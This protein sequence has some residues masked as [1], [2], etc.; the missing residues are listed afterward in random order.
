M[1]A[2]EN[3]QK[4]LVVKSPSNKKEQKKF[5]GYEWCGAKGQ[6]GIKY[7]GGDTVNDIITPLFNPKNRND[8]T[9]INYLIQQNFLGGGKANDLNDF[10]EYKDLITY[11]NVTDLLD[12]SRKDF[13][14]AI[15]L[16]PKK[17][18]IIET[19]WPLVKLGDEVIC[20]P[21]KSEISNLND[22]TIVSFI[23]MSSVSNKGYIKSKVDKT[24]KELKKGGFTYFRE[25]DIIIA[26]ITPSME[27]GKCA[28][29]KDLTNNIGLGS[30]EFHIFRPN[31][32]LLPGYL[33]ALLNQ[34]FIRIEAAVQMTG[35][36]GHRRVPIEFYE[37][38]KIPLPPK[39]IQ[40]KIV[41]ECEAIDKEVEKAQETIEKA[42]KEI[43]NGFNELLAKANKT[44][45]LNNSDIFEVSIGKRVVAKEIENTKKGIPVYSANVYEP[46]GYINK[47]LLK[48]FDKPSVLWGIDGDWMVNYIEKDKPFYPTDHC[49]VLRV[50]GNEIHPRYLTFALEKAGKEVRFSRNHRAS[51]DRIKGLTI[52]APDYKL[53]KQFAEKVEKLEAKIKQAKE[54]INQAKEKKEYIL[55]KY[56]K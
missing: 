45:K 22:N 12:F 4:V 34:D 11:A 26:K 56:L 23:E 48:D 36:S 24:I 51:I 14:K 19:K 17:K 38:M 43:E 16:N 25:N 3:N 35:S 8:K 13:N 39:E 52:K 10:E 21:S 28:L 47:S 7:L 50:K 30:T 33:F 53:Q 37:N 29:A 46:F 42:E 32:K 15:S 55:N 49:G 44:F 1:L 20:N 31:N 40:E 2:Y 5:L 41:S 6:E 27:N 18:I 9:K 54:I